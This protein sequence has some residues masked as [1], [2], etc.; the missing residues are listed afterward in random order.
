MTEGTTAS[1]WEQ[2]EV[3]D[4]PTDWVARHVRSYVETNGRNGHLFHGM[5]TLLLTTRGRRTGQHRRTA[6][7]YAEAG[8]SYLLVA[9]NGGSARHPAWFLNLEADPA[10][11]VQVG[12][13][14]FA[15]WA[16]IAGPTEKPLLWQQMA[17]IF[18]TYDRYQAK[19]GR[20]IPVVILDR[21]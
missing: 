14:V 1:D 3:V 15:A 21:A 19:A 16:R 5:P 7:I 2:Q 11:D 9:S 6:L 12:A 18:P 8:E 4:S 10:V 13:E 17:E 20:D